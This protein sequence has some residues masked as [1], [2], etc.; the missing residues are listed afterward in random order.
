MD[1]D[2]TNKWMEK[3]EALNK[4]QQ[5]AVYSADLV[6]LSNDPEYPEPS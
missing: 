4:L 5:V 2:D 3:A 6:L 1:G